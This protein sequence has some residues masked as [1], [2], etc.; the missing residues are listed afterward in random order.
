M[1]P[2]VLPPEHEEVR[3]IPQPPSS[4][5]QKHASRQQTSHKDSHSEKAQQ[6]SVQNGSGKEMTRKHEEK[7][8]SRPMP[9]TTSQVVLVSTSKPLP[10]EDVRKEESPGTRKGLQLQ[11]P[12]LSTGFVEQPDQW[13]KPHAIDLEAKDAHG[14][15]A[16]KDFLPS[17]GHALVQS[18]VVQVSV[19]QTQLPQ[20]KNP[21]LKLSPR[22]SDNKLESKDSVPDTR[23]R[24]PE[25]K[26]PAAPSSKVAAMVA[27]KLAAVQTPSEEQDIDTS[28]VDEDKAP[29][30]S[31]SPTK[32]LPGEDLEQEESTVDIEEQEPE[33]ES[34]LPWI[35]TPPPVIEED[36]VESPDAV[37]STGT[38]RA[39]SPETVIVNE[40]DDDSQDEEDKSSGE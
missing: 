5:T 17:E 19:T 10:V 2:F 30:I 23:T 29:D 24:A 28:D 8:S 1:G 36:S 6:V 26:I 27:Q 20:K 14:V 34:T 21:P 38:G 35:K 25:S 3:P 13:Q 9:M 18:T 4:H 16:K 37:S 22:A 7:I 33:K 40:G 12:G 39:K 15:S 31:E 32:A 11:T